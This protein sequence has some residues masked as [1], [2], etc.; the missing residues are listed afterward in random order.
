MKSNINQKMRME[1]QNQKSKYAR[2]ILR[3]NYR[4]NPELTQK[5]LEA[6]RALAYT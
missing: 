5:A 3:R 6:S 2:K 4:N 1:V